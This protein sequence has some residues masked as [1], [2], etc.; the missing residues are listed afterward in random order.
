MHLG[1][2]GRQA[3]DHGFVFGHAARA[4]VSRRRFLRRS[5]VAVGALAGA[6]LFD[7]AAAFGDGSGA[8]PRPIPGGF[9][10][11]FNPVPS[12]PF[13]HVLPPAVGFEMSSITDFNGVVGAG[14]TQ[15]TANNG[16][17]NF[18]CD[19]RFMQGLYAGVDGRLRQGS[20]GFI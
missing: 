16:A 13:V 10:Q 17:Y 20:F 18:D 9:D 6:G 4:G 14:E 5:A 11:F 7:V 12:D 3:G 2:D 8:D 15:G 1:S 19:M